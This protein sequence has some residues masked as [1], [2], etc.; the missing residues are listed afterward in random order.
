MDKLT[1]FLK[2]ISSK[3]RATITEILQAVVSGKINNLDIKKLKGFDSVYRVKVVSIRIVFR[4]DGEHI[5]VLDISRRG[6]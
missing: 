1:K 5:K 4:R 6:E 3:E 2:K